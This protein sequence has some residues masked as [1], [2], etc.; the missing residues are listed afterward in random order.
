M[1]EESSQSDNDKNNELD[2]GAYS[3]TSQAQSNPVKSTAVAKGKKKVKKTKVYTD[4]K[5]Y[6]V[7]EEYSEYE[8]ADIP[9]KKEIS[10]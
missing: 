4:E 6:M 7:T 10:C 1:L 2:V 9:V 5:G 8:D 3:G